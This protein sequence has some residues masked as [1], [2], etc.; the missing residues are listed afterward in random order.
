MS[1]ESKVVV[2]TGAS[3]G[4]GRAIA[5]CFAQRGA[6]VALLSRDPDRMQQVRT[7]IE[8]AGGQ[9]LA[10]EVDVADAGAVEAAASAV[11]AAWGDI[12]VWVNNAMVSVYSFAHEMTAEEFKRVTEVT[13]LGTV[14]GTLAALKRMIPRDRGAIVQVGSGLAYRGI[15]FQSAYCASKH[16]VEGLLD[17]LRAELVLLKS[18]VRVTMVHMPA[19]N[20]P[21]FDWVKSR[22]PRKSQ[23]VPPIFQ[24]EVGARAVVWAAEGYRPRELNVGFNPRLFLAKIFPWAG[25]WYLGRFGYRQEMTDEPENPARPHNLWQTVRG[26]FGAHGRF[27]H[28]AR[29]KSRYLQLRMRLYELF[30]PTRFSH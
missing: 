19:M 30:N 26:N 20:T 27:D 24:P 10:F 29:T 17:S 7:E 15:P 16:A 11:E 25:D 22:L 6:R 23:P 14:Y 21:Q 13:Y 8:L 9:C 28:V 12:D 1:L 3:A 5:E 4:L 2:V 18:N